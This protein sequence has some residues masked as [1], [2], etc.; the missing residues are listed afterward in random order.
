MEGGEGKAQEVLR[1]AIAMELE[2]KEFFERA[3]RRM[4]RKRSKDMFTGLAVQE[5]RHIDILSH[6]LRRLEDGRGWAGLEDAKT[7][8]CPSSNSPV[9]SEEGAGRLKLNA[10][11]GELEVIDLGIEV[12]KN[13]IDYYRSASKASKDKNA[14]EV[15]DWLVGEESGHLTILRAERDS[16]SGAGFH[17]DSQ[18]FSLETQ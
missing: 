2:G 15:F 8:Q 9:F 16:R 6:E 1:D 18:E 7:A 5:R 17:Y 10:D 11:A 12:E 4:T 13:S 3:S 14:R